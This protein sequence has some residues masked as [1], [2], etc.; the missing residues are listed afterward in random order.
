MKKNLILLLCLVSIYCGK[1]SEVTWNTELYSDADLTTKIMDVK[2]GTVGTAS[3]Y[4]NHKWNQKKSIK[5]MIDGKEGY[6]SPKYVVI[7]Q[8]PEKSVFKWGY[9]T[10]YKK[11]YEAT[12]KK[13]YKEGYVYPSLDTLPKDKIPLDDLLK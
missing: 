4:R 9:N 2:K 3:E 1:N 11:F 12:D 13:H 8:D 7:G 10:K 5:I 6:I